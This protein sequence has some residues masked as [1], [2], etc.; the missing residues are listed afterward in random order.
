[1]Y[2]YP[3][4][5]WIP[6]FRKTFSSKQ[7]KPVATDD[8][9]IPEHEHDPLEYDQHESI[10]T[11]RASIPT[12]EPTSQVVKSKSQGKMKTRRGWG[13]KKYKKVIKF[14]IIG[15]NCNGLK[16]KKESLFSAIRNFNTPSCI[17]IQ[18]TKLRFP[19]TFKI[20]GYQIFE[21]TR[22]G[23]GGGLLTAID[24]NLSPLLISSGSNE[25]EILI[26]QAQV[27]KHSIRINNGYGPQETEVK[28]KIYSFW[29]EIEKEIINA[30]EANCFI[31]L[32]M[33]A[34][35]KLGCE[36]IKNDP[37][38]MS[39]NGMLLY[40]I[41]KRQN[42]SCLNAH[43][44]CEGSITRHRKTIFGDEKA[45]LDY[46]IVCLIVFQTFSNFF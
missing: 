29:E 15:N 33:D 46:I 12:T 14:S 17:I 30:K 38:Q 34:N 35:A 23:Q 43:R 19:G 45:I 26:I 36:V 32:Q 44:L 4:T 41:L 25:E 7:H 28:E 22:V 2:V 27:G 16:A 24:C 6:F 1:M 11:N 37:N 13:K 18:E 5:E 10:S 3:S 31:L 9:P 42:L 8:E 20:P 21:K 40:N 39:E